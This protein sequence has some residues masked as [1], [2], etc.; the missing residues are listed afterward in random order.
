MT[1]IMMAVLGGAGGPSIP[2]NTV[3]PVVTGTAQVGQTLSCTTGTWTGKAPIT[4]TY[5]WQYGVSNTNISG[6]TSSTYVIQSAYVGQTIRC[7]VTATNSIGAVSAPSNSTSAVSATVPTAPTVGTVNYATATSLTVNYTASS[8]DGGSTITSYTAVSSPGNITGSISTSG[9]GTITVS[10]LT[11]GQAYTFVVYATNAIGNSANSASSASKIASTVPGA[12][13]IGTATATGQTTASV[14][15]TPPADDGGQT[16]TSYTVTSSA[17]QTASG[18]SSPITVSGLAP[19]SSYTFTVK[20]TN[21][22]GQSSASAASNSITTQVGGYLGLIGG[23][24]SFAY[25]STNDGGNFTVAFSGDAGQSVAS[26]NSSGGVISSRASGYEIAVLQGNTLPGGIINPV[27][28]SNNSSSYGFA[29]S[30]NLLTVARLDT[31]H[32]VQGGRDTSGN[33]Y[34]IARPSVNAI[35]M[36]KYNSTGTEQWGRQYSTCTYASAK[37]SPSGVT[38][39]S[40]SGNAVGIA[41]VNTSGAELWNKA[42]SLALGVTFIDSSNNLYAGASASPGSIAKFDSSGNVSWSRTISAGAPTYLGPQAVDS[43]GNVYVT[44]YYYNGTNTMLLV[45]FNSS[46]TLQWQRTLASTGGALIPSSISADDVWVYLAVSDQGSS[47][48]VIAKLP[49]S[50]S[51]TGSYA[52]GAFTFTYAAGAATI[53]S[54]SVTVS[55]P[56]ASGYSNPLGN[57]SVSSAAT[58]SAALT[59]TIVGI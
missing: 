8:S 32:H 12:P 13:T 48:A 17:G 20:A 11:K 36:F 26:F 15:F 9:S 1:G 21:P 4:Y 3:A 33:W 43:A 49:G 47:R 10:G 55:A 34:R 52:V 25:L 22:V 41:V 46:G 39:I 50:G 18:A 58:S 27:K 56:G 19:G 23:T 24:S 2:V 35:N 16:I 30:S 40:Y 42:T 45:K 38:A 6:Q 54:G 28:G 14:T 29:I 31:T 51:G 5:Q 37:V 7:L 44:G 57:S 53:S 59:S